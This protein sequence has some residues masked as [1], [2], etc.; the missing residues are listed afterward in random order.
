[1][2]FFNDFVFIWLRNFIQLDAT[3]K[4]TGATRLVP[5]LNKSHILINDVIH[6]RTLR[7]L[8]AFSISFLRTPLDETRGPD[9]AA[10]F[11]QN[12]VAVAY[13]GGFS[14]CPETPP[15]GHDFF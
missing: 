7:G 2:C 9:T 1:M 5:T 14:G 3:W 4:S 11:F 13:P 15:P 10:T 8:Y 6:Y 12:S